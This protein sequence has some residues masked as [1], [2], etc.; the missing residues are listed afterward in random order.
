MPGKVRIGIIGCGAIARY[1]HLR[2]YAQLTDDVEVVAL[3]DPFREN[4]HLLGDMHDVP[5][6]SRYVS[7]EDLLARDDIDAVSICTPNYLHGPQTVDA[8]QAG[9]HVL[10]E[11][12][13]TTTVDAA[14]AMVKAAEETDKI[15]MVGF[16][17]RYM[18]HNQVTKELLDEGAIGKP[19]MIRVR[20][21]HDGPYKSWAAT[22]DW[23]FRPEKAGGGALLDMGIHAL[24]ICRYMLGEITNVTGQLGTFGKDIVVEDTAVINLGF[25][26]HALGYIETGWSSKEGVLG[27]EIYGTEGS[28]VVDYTTPIRLFRVSTGKWEDITDA[29]NDAAVTEM[30]HFVECIKSGKQPMTNGKDGLISVKLAA[31][32]YE[33]A[34]TGC[35]VCLD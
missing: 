16:T 33:S 17:H 14:T 23:F 28:I 22:T 15:L 26:D 18:K 8:L 24:D 12:P 7:Y 5:G 9:K 34:K 3:A 19:F 1:T 35:A 10:C 21:A 32:V 27:L 11:K 30:R 31:A 20:F 2:G 13:M 25:G 29:K 4:L 6:N